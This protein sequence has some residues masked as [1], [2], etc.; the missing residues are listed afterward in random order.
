MR[1]I[2][3]AEDP[4]RR[5]EDLRHRYRELWQSVV[6]PESTLRGVASITFENAVELSR[7]SGPE[8]RWSDTQVHVDLVRWA[9]G[10]LPAGS[11]V[12]PTWGFLKPDLGFLARSPDKRRYVVAASG[13]L[14]IGDRDSE[15]EDSRGDTE[16]QAESH[17]QRNDMTRPWITAIAQETI[18]ALTVAEMFGSWHGVVG[19]DTILSRLVVINWR[20]GERFL[21]LEVS[22]HLRNA[23][24]DQ[25]VPLENV[26]NLIRDF[27]GRIG[28]L[29][30][31]NEEGD[32]H[33]A[34]LRR[35][36]ALLHSSAVRLAEMDVDL[37]EQLAQEPVLDLRQSLSTTAD[38]DSLLFSTASLRR[39]L[40]VAAG[41]LDLDRHVGENPSSEPGEDDE[42][43]AYLDPPTRRGSAAP[44][45]PPARRVT[46]SS[47]LSE[48]PPVNPLPRTRSAS[49]PPPA[50]ATGPGAAATVPRES[51]GGAGQDA[52]ASSTSSASQTADRTSAHLANWLVS[53]GLSVARARALHPGRQSPGP[54]GAPSDSSL[55]SPEYLV[56]LIGTLE[57]AV[58]PAT[59]TEMDV[60]L[61]LSA[62]TAAPAHGENLHHV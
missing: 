45:S 1:I 55:V 52:G 46:R 40:S 57:V 41:A 23:L 59:T 43:D 29:D 17:G 25:Q 39:E 8:V 31:R 28:G 60:L 54:S 35:L 3:A 49:P 14:R 27:D 56:D 36:W 19:V 34:D 38:G 48:H 12:G 61:G 15:D 16:Q 50:T 9:N 4:Y 24:G 62:E 2:L 26:L 53:Q 30:L 10:A 37:R 7:A 58:W 44:R 32:V 5:E 11:V 13:E 42:S 18:Y 51:R 47:A 20:R 33:D 6:G 21:A 22:P